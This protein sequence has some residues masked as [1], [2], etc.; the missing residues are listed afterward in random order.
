M[1]RFMED[2]DIL[3]QFFPSLFEPWI[4]PLRIQFQ[5]KSPTFDELDAIKRERLQIHFFSDAFTAVV[6]VVA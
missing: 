2:V 5:E 3:R 1:R 6:V 4:T